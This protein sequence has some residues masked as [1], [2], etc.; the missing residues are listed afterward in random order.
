MLGD[1][2][3]KAREK[4][5]MTQEELA[6]KAQV[7]RTYVSLLERDKKSPTLNMLFRLCEAMGA[8]A[9]RI[10]A[11]IERASYGKSKLHKS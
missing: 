3:R 8:S 6:F 1:E 10:V 2:L 7:H 9:S 4:A 5:G 11:K